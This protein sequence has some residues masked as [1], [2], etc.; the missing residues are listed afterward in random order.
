MMKVGAK[1]QPVKCAARFYLNFRKHYIPAAS[2]LRVE[3][4][5]T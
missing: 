1:Q 2:V 4:G 5:R 3:L